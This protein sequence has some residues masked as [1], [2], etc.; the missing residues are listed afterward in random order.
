MASL[1]ADVDAILD[2]RVLEPEAA[3]AELEE[4][5]VLASLFIPL[6]HRRP[7][8]VSVPRGIVPK[9]VRILR[10]GRRSILR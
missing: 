9:R 2:V 8:H 7:R 5:T 3:P 1:R 10:L 4:D 6:L